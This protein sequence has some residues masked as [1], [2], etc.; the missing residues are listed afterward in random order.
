M[1]LASCMREIPKLDNTP[2]ERILMNYHRSE[3]K[4]DA[5]EKRAVDI[6][7]YPCMYS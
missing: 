5:P 2:N 4:R 6:E 1:T 7:S 3:E